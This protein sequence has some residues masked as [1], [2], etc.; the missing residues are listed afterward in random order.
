[1]SASRPWVG[2]SVS[3][4]RQLRR[5]LKQ[6]GDDL[7]DLKDAHAAAAAIVAARARANAPRKSGRLAGSVRSS[8][9]ASRAA[10][11]AGRKPIPY[12][13]VQNFGWPARNIAPNPFMTTA[14]DQTREQWLPAYKSA[15]DDLVQ[16]IEETT[17]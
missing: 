8:G 10:I 11:R 4:G 16:R 2:V 5:A 12:A 15:L 1:M 13:G 6:A 3:G 17:E 14:I 7:A 9:L